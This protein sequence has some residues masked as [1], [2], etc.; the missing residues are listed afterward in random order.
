[1]LTAAAVRKC[2]KHRLVFIKFLL[3]EW[4]ELSDVTPELNATFLVY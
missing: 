4:L 2:H 1:V 3:I